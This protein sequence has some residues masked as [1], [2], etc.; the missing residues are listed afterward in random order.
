MCV[1]TATGLAGRSGNTAHFWVKLNLTVGQ[2]M[3]TVTSAWRGARGGVRDARDA[4]CSGGITVD[5]STCAARGV[6]R[7]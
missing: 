2:G 1:S 6:R 3:R 7:G 4:A 5:E